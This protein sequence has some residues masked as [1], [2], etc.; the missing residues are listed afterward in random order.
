MI[1]KKLEKHLLILILSIFVSLSTFA[2][3]QKDEL[4]YIKKAED[5]LYTNPRLSSMYS[6]KII[7]S[8]KDDH[9]EK[10]S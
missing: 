5:E 6:L 8:N 9:P 3:G 4:D 1:E 2:S 7:N 10:K